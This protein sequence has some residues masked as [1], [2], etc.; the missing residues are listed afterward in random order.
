MIGNVNIF[1]IIKLLIIIVV[2]VVFVTS[3]ISMMNTSYSDW[4]DYYNSIM[5][6]KEMQ[7]YLDSLPLTFEGVSAEIKEDVVFYANGKAS[8]SKDDL[9]VVA[10]FSEKGKTV[11]K[12]LN[13]SDFEIEVPEKFADRGGTVI[14]KYLY[15]PE[16]AADAT[17]E[18]PAILRIAEVKVDLVPVVLTSL[19]VKVN[20]YRVYYKESMSFDASGIQLEAVY[21]DGDAVLINEN[22]VDVLTTGALTNDISNAKVAYTNRGVTVEAEI[23]ITVKSEAEY[24]DGDIVALDSEGKVYIIHGQSLSEAKPTIRATYTSGNKLIISSD[25]L[26]ISGNVETASF[27]TNCVITASL[28]DNASISCET[29]AVVRYVAE[30]EDAT[31]VGGTENT[32]TVN[33][34]QITV[35]EG[36]ANG[37]TLTFTINS[38]ALVKGHPSLRLANNSLKSVKASDIIGIKVNGRSYLVPA[39]NLAAK[40]TVHG[41]N[42]LDVVLPD[43]VLNE[44]DNIIEI[45]FN[46]MQDVNL[47]IDGLNIEF[48]EETSSELT[49]GEQVTAVKD[50]DE[51]AT[52]TATA[53]PATGTVGKID[54]NVAKVT[55]Q[56]Y[57]MGGVSDG[58]Y[59][60]V[61]MNTLNNTATVI[62]KVDP[63]TNTVVAQT[64]SFVPGV[65]KVDNSRIFIID[66]MLYCIIQDGSM[67]E[68]DLDLFNGFECKVKKANLSLAKYGTAFDATWNESNGKIAL[69]TKENKLHILNSDLTALASDISAVN[70]SAAASSVTSDDK[71]IYV[72]YMDGRNVL[73]DVYTWLGEKVDRISVTGFVF[74]TETKYNVQAIFMHDGQLHAAVCSWGTTYKN[75]FFDWVINADTNS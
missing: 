57:S 34:Q 46:D 62:S 59:I 44:G 49:F 30:A 5:A 43:V 18:P 47:A 56:I 67:Y 23:S 53:T 69:I 51:N 14:V 26:I 31:A 17:E 71:F 6:E 73:V 3:A 68:I 45:T 64:V 10:H 25:E 75:A 24:D 19:N 2:A 20:P 33:E 7:K 74:G 4:Q 15:Q 36:F 21:N 70:G 48:D 55:G 27:L 65:Q 11:D 66:N 13:S 32:V 40:N 60:Y 37:N 63:D 28:K 52:I 35:I 42:F 9:K 39:Y 50:K 16:K 41:Y 22:D 29:A 58:K 72:S 38:G 12:I 54:V 8:I 1:T 61:S